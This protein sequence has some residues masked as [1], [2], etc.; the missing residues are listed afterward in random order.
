MGL[1]GA[2]CSTAGGLP[3]A[4]GEAADLRCEAAQVFLKSNRQWRMGPL[5]PEGAATFRAGIA[6]ATPLRVIAHATYLINLA[7]PEPRTQ[8]LSRETLALEVRRAADTGIESVVLHPGAHMGRGEDAGIEAVA[9]AL[10]DVL[11]ETRDCP[12]IV[13][14]ENAAG[15]GTTLGV[16][17]AE[18]ARMMALAGDDARLG[19]CFDTCHAF[20]AGYD[21]ATDEGYDATM[22]EL[23]ATIGMGRLRAV[24]L[25]DSVLPV[26]S[27]RDRHANL[28][29]GVMGRTPFRR[30]VNDARLADVP[31]ILE[32]P[33]GMDGYR[34][35][36]AILRRLR[37]P[38]ARR[39]P[40]KRRRG[41]PA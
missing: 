13:L 22:A 26:G 3:T 6:P 37:R 27:R 38:A 39:A 15:Q 4:L 29:E 21:I 35:D 32:T 41:P 10:R 1:L 16:R 40:A 23:D 28:D 33:G 17:F 9:A 31:M 36:L 24:H 2:H 11:A 30:I 20:A 19:A 5:D 7:A 8:A 14:L 18:L 25:N 12:V 34:N